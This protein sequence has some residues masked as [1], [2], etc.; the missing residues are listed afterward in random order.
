MIVVDVN[1][2]V[3]AFR[4]DAQVHA[5]M[6]SWLDGVLGSGRAVAAPAAALSGFLRV[7][8]HPQ[9]FA[10]PSTLREALDFV[11]ALLGVDTCVIADAGERH[12]PIL[13]DLLVQADARGNLVPDAHLCAVALEHGATIATRD[14]GFSRFPGVS[15][16][17]PVATG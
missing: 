6:K 2:L 13:R 1:V 12:W 3:A 9:I 5:E 11:D 15:W 4:E 14:R 10:A 8:T 16:F 17:D 7:V